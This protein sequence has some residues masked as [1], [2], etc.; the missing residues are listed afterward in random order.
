M[1]VDSGAA[2]ADNWTMSM[3]VDN[4]YNVYFGD[5]FLSSPTFVGGSANW[6]VTDTWNISGVAS[7]DDLYVATASDQQVC[8]RVS[9]RVHEPYQ[10]LLVRDQR[11]QWHPLA[12]LCRGSLPAAV[13]CDR[14]DDSRGHLAGVG[15]ADPG[16]GPRGR[17]LCHD[18]QLLAHA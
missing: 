9:W 13:A 15:P 17:H 10:R 1:L 3:T 4:Q 7:T 8:A 12:S 18:E 11:V 16:P 14:S 2:R 5:Q 6:P